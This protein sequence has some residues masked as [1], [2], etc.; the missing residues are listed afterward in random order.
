VTPSPRVV[1]PLERAP[2]HR[3]SR[4][5]SCGSEAD[6]AGPAVGSP[7][8]AAPSASAASAATGA[9]S[10]STISPSRQTQSVTIDRQTCS[11]FQRPL[12]KR[13]RITASG[14]L[15]NRL[16]ANGQSN[17]PSSRQRNRTR[18]ECRRIHPERAIRASTRATWSKRDLHKGPTA[19]VFAP[20][21][22]LPAQRAYSRLFRPARRSVSLQAFELVT[23]RASREMTRPPARVESQSAYRGASSA[24]RLRARASRSH[25]CSVYGA[26]W[27]GR[28]PRFRYPSSGGPWEE[29]RFRERS[30]RRVQSSLSVFQHSHPF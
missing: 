8:S 24:G 9:G 20:S 7:A 30:I 22:F 16:W 4:S 17:R 10:T 14:A 12:A 3:R 28:G 15:A 18:Q 2:G 5:E 23:P 29:N 21:V 25:R 6:H 13:R 1:D 11:T 26:T 19:E 27:H